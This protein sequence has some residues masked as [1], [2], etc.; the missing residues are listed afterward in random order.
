[1]KKALLIIVASTIML[2]SCKKVKELFDVTFTFSKSFDFTLPAFP[3]P[4]QTVDTSFTILLPT[5]AN[6]IPDEFSKYKADIN[7]IKELSI[8]D[9]V[10]TIK[11]PTGQTFDFMKKID[12]YL[13][14]PGKPEVL[15]ATKTD[16]Q[17]I[18]PSTATLTLDNQ[19]ANVIE[20]IKGDSIYLKVTCGLYKT[21]INDIGTNADIK[22]K[23]VANPLN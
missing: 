19:N 13:G 4:V 12:I 2:S 7:K 6:T 22:F 10:L 21:Y 9:V 3:E 23:V 18:N 8:T 1:M 17:N 5:V 15:I 11:S 20:L 16:I 14:A